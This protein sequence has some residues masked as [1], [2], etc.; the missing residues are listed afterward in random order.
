MT[1]HGRSPRIDF[2]LY[3]ITNQRACG[4][5]DLMPVVEEALKGGVKAVQ[6]REKDLSS[7]ELYEL[8]QEMRDITSRYG[9]RL[10]INDR[11]DIALA[12]DADGVHL[13]HG[14]IPIQIARQ[15]MGE[16][17]LIGISCHGRE[18]AVAAQEKGAD[19]ITYGPVFHTPSKAAYGTP[20]GIGS[21]REVTS[22]LRI[23]VFALGG[24]IGRNTRQ[25]IDAGAHGI[26][27]I[28]AVIAAENP[29]EEAKKLLALLHAVEHQEE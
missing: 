7:R 9:A 28:S 25:V 22:R 18:S 23:P 8:A 21:L 19:F 13:G 14:S 11:I 10:F 16:E 1:E 24:I 2:N 3:L 15:L 29:R 20:V 27:L 4:W 17:K 12:V 26:A 6:L 5:R